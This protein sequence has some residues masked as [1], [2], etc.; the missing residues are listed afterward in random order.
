MKNICFPLVLMVLCGCSGANSFKGDGESDGEIPG[1]SEGDS[2]SDEDEG[3]GDDVDTDGDT[4]PDWEDE[5]SDGDGIPDDV[6]AGDDDPDTPPV[7]SDGDGIP[8]F[9][10]LDSDGNGVLDADEG[11][12]D[13]DG[14]GLLDYMD[15]D[16]DGD[17][18]DDV[19]E[20]GGNPAE[21]LD[22]DGD[23]VE[24]YFDV[25]SD[26]DTIGDA[27]ERPAD[28]DVDGDGLP[29]R[30]DLDT[31][32]DGIPDA[33]EAGDDDLST[34]PVDTDGDG[35]P[36]FRDV[37]SDN[38]GLSDEWE[39]DNGTDPYSEDSDGDGVPDLIEVGA[40]TDPT[41]AADNPRL[42]GDFVFVVPYN[43]PVDPPSTPLDPEP[44][45]DHLLFQTDLKVADVFFTL[46]SSGSMN[47]EIANLRSSIRSTVVP[48]IRAAIPDVW[49][50]VGR[51]EDCHSCAHNMSVMQAITDSVTDVESALTGWSTCGGSEPY[52]HNLYALAT[53]DL[54]DVLGWGGI[55][56][57]TWTCT[58]PGSI[59]WPCFRYGAL[60][61]IIQFGDEPWTGAISDCT[62]S[63][64]HDDAID[65][66]VQISAK[67][68][69]V[70]S[71]SSHADMVI[72]AEGTS[73]VDTSGDP[74]VFDISSSGTGLGTQVVDAVTT[75][76]TEVTVSA[77]TELRDDPTD[78]VD[79]VEAFIDFVEP[80]AVG[81]H[82]DPADSTLVCEGGLSV[83]DVHEPFDGRP[84]S[85]THVLP[86]TLVC[87]DIHVKQNWTVPAS[88]EP[89]S[90][91]CE[92]DV[93]ANTVTTLDTRVIYFLVPPV[94]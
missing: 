60:P 39:R 73:S 76:A 61:I 21:P 59:G 10:D 36:D 26:G 66:L 13:A 91:R 35:T 63:L 49:I 83:G 90:F 79:T 37:D 62:P 42:N 84:D 29:D 31:D 57:T 8:D 65:G 74:L 50:G 56:P 7:D 1:D 25:D 88:S 22:T 4:V 70:N 44:V 80:S 48:G 87:F 43:D 86:G 11:Y 28:S 19:T 68:I 2:I 16:N 38:D 40:G 82:S 64:D 5:D 34:P 6:E 72:V 3:R 45:V 17:G 23:G 89:R 53:G 78:L 14:D 67:Y 52:T 92:I 9:R 27:D 41:D 12:G 32:G 20:I 55:H 93:I 77:T 18:I 54:T 85:F 47:G 24:D 46:D 51:F 58:P 30:R 75:L 81:G 15:P 69:G 33:E 94:F 71:G